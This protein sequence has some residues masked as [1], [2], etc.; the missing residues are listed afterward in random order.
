M[1]LPLAAAARD[2]LTALFYIRGLPMEAGS[3]VALPLNDGSATD[4]GRFDRRRR[5]DHS[6][7]A[8][9]A[10]LEARAT[11]DKIGSRVAVRWT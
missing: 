7:R 3:H 2:P 4:P 8:V 10:G 6:R 1:T 11:V 9:E 5:D